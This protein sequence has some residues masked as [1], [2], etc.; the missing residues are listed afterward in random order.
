MFQKKAK[1]L[2]QN[3]FLNINMILKKKKKKMIAKRKACL[4]ARGLTQKERID[5]NE[6]FSPTLKQNSLR[7]ITLLT[8]HW[9]ENT[10]D[11]NFFFFLFY[12]N[13]FLSD[14]FKI[15]I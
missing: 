12:I 5:Y 15:A 11:L 7:L 2:L 10:S 1:W 8:A 13:I 3:G 14:F 9:V 4:V 6:T